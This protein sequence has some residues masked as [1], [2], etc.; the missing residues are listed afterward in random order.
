[1]GNAHALE[2]VCD[3]P[4]DLTVGNRQDPLCE[5][6]IFKGSFGGKQLKI[7]KD[8]AKVLVGSNLKS[9]SQARDVATIDDDVP[10]I[11]PL[12]R[13]QK[14]EQRRLAGATRPREHG[15]LPGFHPKSDILKSQGM[16]RKALE[17]VQHL[18]H[19]ATGGIMVPRL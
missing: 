19:E 16:G 18:D 8:N 11:R 1:M 15:E 10:P 13:I 17:D 14:P 12:R 3:P 9:W 4:T 7:L 6:N 2:D 5:G